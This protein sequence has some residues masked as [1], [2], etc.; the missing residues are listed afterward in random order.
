[1]QKRIVNLL[2]AL[3]LTLLIFQAAVAQTEGKAAYG[4]LIDNTGSLRTQF[5]DVLMLS[6]EIVGQI[7]QRGSISLFNFETQ[8]DEKHPLAVVTSGTEWSQDNNR[9]GKYIDK[10]F[11]VPG[12]TT[13]MDAINSVA[14]R[15]DAKANLDKEAV[16]EKV[17]LLIT[18]GEDRVSKIKEKELIK[19]LK[20]L[21]IKVY[22][23]GLI[24]EL[25]NEDSLLHKSKR[26][27]AID[28]LAKLTKETGGRVV[29]PH[30]K[31]ADVR[32]LLNELFR[33]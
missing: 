26:E 23:V 27:K 31:K 20:G 33:K 22:A 28:F 29:F 11:V 14:E 21:G 15:L 19:T 12:R 2:P 1:M 3:L 4:I 8:G 24:K 17:I 7:H 25:N 18:D 5:P 32:S 30:S 16:G 9:I 10:L 6:K 13:L